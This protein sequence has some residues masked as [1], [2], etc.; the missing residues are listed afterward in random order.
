MALLACMDL[1]LRWEQLV[2]AAQ[3]STLAPAAFREMDF[4]AKGC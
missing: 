4:P 1:G 3:P 2:L